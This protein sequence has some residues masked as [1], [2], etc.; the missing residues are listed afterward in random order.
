MA[1]AV[2]EAELSALLQDVEFTRTYG[3]A[4]HA[5]GD[6]TCVLDV[7]FRKAFER[8]G[9]IV[10]GQVF[11]AAAD[12]AMWLAIMTRLGR[13]D[14][15]VTAEMSTAFLGAA[16]AEPFRCAARILKLGRRLIYGVAESAAGD[17][18]LLAHHTIT[19]IR[20]GAA[21]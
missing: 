14:R 12:V 6:G 11:M 8:P 10:S 20:P 18:R 2:T 5:I 13:Q 19:Y 7:P 17:G 4:L 21:D 1:L 15:S 16:R 9:G 3:F